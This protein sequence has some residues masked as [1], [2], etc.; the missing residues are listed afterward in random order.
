M[1]VSESAEL[2]RLMSR[3]PSVEARIHK[4]QT[5]IVALASCRMEELGLTQA[6]LAVKMGKSK[7]RLSQIMSAS[8]NMTLRSI[9]ELEDALDIELI[10]TQEPYWED[11]DRGKGNSSTAMRWR[12][13]GK[14]SSD[15]TRI[16]YHESQHEYDIAREG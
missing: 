10:T 3:P 6:A 12:V 4:H 1:R 2:K 14:D 7:P 11:V 5:D 16:R 15:P 13:Y 8:S 9:S